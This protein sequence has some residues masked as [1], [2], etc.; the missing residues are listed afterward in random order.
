MMTTASCCCTH[1]PA[2]SIKSKDYA[3]HEVRASVYLDG[4]DSQQLLGSFPA[5]SR[6]LLQVVE[7]EL[8]HCA[9]AAQGWHAA[10]REASAQLQQ[11]RHRLRT[12]ACCTPTAAMR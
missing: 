2:D 11:Q 5:S 8:A 1:I 6:S 10:A 12:E 9:S 7:E 4:K 3:L